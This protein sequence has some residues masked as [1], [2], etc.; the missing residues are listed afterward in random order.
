MPSAA[1]PITMASYYGQATPELRLFRRPPAYSR[2]QL[3]RTLQL[4]TPALLGRLWLA[5]SQRQDLLL[6]RDL[7][8][9]QALA[10]RV[11][12]LSFAATDGCGFSRRASAASGSSHRARECPRQQV[13]GSGAKSPLSPSAGAVPIWDLSAPSTRCP[14][15]TWNEAG[16][17]RLTPM[18][19]L[20]LAVIVSALLLLVFSSALL[21]D[22]SQSPVTLIE[23]PEKAKGERP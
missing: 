14:R 3:L 9:A 4:A 5:H 6:S 23:R 20:F 12:K 2:F 17:H 1:A 10:T 21:V 18:D 19:R 13:G 7:T 8:G 16:G 22:R 15:P 11:M